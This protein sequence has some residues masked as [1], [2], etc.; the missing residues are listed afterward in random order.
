MNA[1]LIPL[2]GFAL[3]AALLGFGIHYMRNNSLNEVPSPLI[4]K[5]AP[6]FDLP[7]LGNDEKRISNADLRGQPYLLNV[8]ASWCF[9]C[10]DEHPILM[11]EGKS[12]GIPI[13]GFNYKDDPADATRWLAQFG[14]PYSVVIADR[15]GRVAI[16]FGVYGAPESFLVDGDGIIRY[17]RIGAITPEIVAFELKPRLKAMQGAGK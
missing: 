16:D 4:G 15:E 2:L 10:R 3:V 14:D 7:V 17:K 1:R 8:F 5:P 9:A 12:L 13:I 6:V 11:A